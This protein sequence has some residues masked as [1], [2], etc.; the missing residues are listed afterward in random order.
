[1]LSGAA[2]ELLPPGTE[3]K[4]LTK[5]LNKQQ[6]QNCKKSVGTTAQQSSKSP[7][8]FR[9]AAL[10]AILLLAAVSFVGCNNEPSGDYTQAGT[11]SGNAHFRTIVID[12]CEY[13]YDS[14]IKMSV[15]AVLTHKGNCKFCAARHSR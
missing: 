14:N 5:S 3:D 12:S 10:A 2:I 4:L 15:P 9:P 11:R 13:I 6:M 8:L 1:M 7:L